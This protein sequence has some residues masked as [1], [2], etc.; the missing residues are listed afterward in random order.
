[1][2]GLDHFHPAHRLDVET[3][4]LLVCAQSNRLKMV[5]DAF[6]ERRVHKTYL[7][8]LSGEPEQSEWT[9][10]IPLGFD[11][12]TGI[13]LKMGRGTL[14]AETRFRVL[15]AGTQRSLVQAEPM[16]GRQHQIRVHAQLSGHA[17][18][19][20]KLY[21]PE[22][23]LFFASKERPLTEEEWH[24]LGHTRHALHAWKV[25][26]KLPESTHQF[27]SPLPSDLK[28]LLSP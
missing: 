17:L 26:L 13:R 14:S 27:E 9:V 22:D 11:T 25:V 12:S 5:S 1:M 8:V 21:G 7:A 20:D 2:N 28:Q 15:R 18:V 23:K 4:G 10:E 19:G 16:T 3:S 24:L 6:A